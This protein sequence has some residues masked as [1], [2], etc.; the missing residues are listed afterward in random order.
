MNFFYKIKLFSQNVKK[1]E[2]ERSSKGKRFFI[3]EG[4]L[5]LQEAVHHR[6]RRALVHVDFRLL[7]VDIRPVEYQHEEV[8]T[9]CAWYKGNAVLPIPN[10]FLSRN[11]DV[12]PIWKADVTFELSFV[13]IHLDDNI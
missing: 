5:R 6:H 11:V 4:L 9:R 1:K 10:S 7:L 13:V 2:H 12:F 8:D 3:R